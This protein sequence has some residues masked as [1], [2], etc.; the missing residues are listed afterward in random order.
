M[1]K[2]FIVLAL[3]IGGSFA[4]LSQLPLA[5]VAPYVMPSQ[6]GQNIRYSGTVWDGAISEI[7]YLGT[8]QFQL[9]PKTFFSG[10]LPLT[11]HTRSPAMHL[12]GQAS[13]TRLQD[14]SF[15]G[16]L[17]QLPTRDGR[18]KDLKGSVVINVSELLV[19]E[20]CLS[21]TGI[22]TT[23]FLT[24]NKARWYWQGPKL[25]GPISCEE[26]DLIVE[27][28][29]NESRQRIQADL[30]LSKDGSYRADIS[31]QTNQ[32]E[33]SVVLPLYGFEQVG[34]EYKLTEQ[35]QWR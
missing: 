18:L 15:I 5:W 27:L 22:A 2:R 20:G 14:I 30:R 13:K 35:G 12:S 4:A 21:A 10:G 24:Q 1:K 29:G 17:A 32:K 7:D 19:G 11:F 25:S 31:V 23:D 6:I 28:S 26:G 34:R 33:A 3:V 8:A 9:S 16:Q